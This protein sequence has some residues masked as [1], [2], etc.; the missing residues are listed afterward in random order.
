MRREV[1]VQV[2]TEVNALQEEA[3]LVAAAK[4]DGDAFAT[5][6]RRYRRTVAVRP[7]SILDHFAGYGPKDTA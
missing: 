1:T 5:L 2:D 3:A 7:R 6:Y 4:N